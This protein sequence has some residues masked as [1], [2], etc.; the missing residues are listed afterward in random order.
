MI[1]KNTGK[2]HLQ[3][4]GSRPRLSA[5]SG[6]GSGTFASNRRAFYDYLVLDLFEAGIML[7]GSEVK[8][9]RAGTASIKEAVIIVERGEM[10]LYGAHIPKWVSS[11]LSGYDPLRKRKLLLHRREIDS[12]IGKVKEK[13]LTLIPLKLYGCRGRIKIEVGLCRGKKK[14]EKKDA[15]KER[16]LKRELHEEKRKYMV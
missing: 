14:F 1:R 15:E 6:H 3:Q 7:T 2:A 10:W 11:S 16:S 4:H 8:S 5:D 12:V 13:H 9:I